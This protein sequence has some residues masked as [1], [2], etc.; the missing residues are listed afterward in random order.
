MVASSNLKDKTL[1]FPF[2]FLSDTIDLYFN[3]RNSAKAASEIRKV[4]QILIFFLYF[5]NIIMRR[6]GPKD[7]TFLQY[8]LS[9]VFQGVSLGYYM[10]ILGVEP[11]FSSWK[12]DVVTASPPSRT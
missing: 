9:V 10:S 3:V 7:S 1:F 8:A 11:A 6:R 4:Y 12:V 2:Y 5:F